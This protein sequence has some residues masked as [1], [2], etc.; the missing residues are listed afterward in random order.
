MGEPLIQTFICTLKA[1]M[2]IAPGDPF[3]VPA[4]NSMFQDYVAFAYS[5]LLSYIRD[6]FSVSSKSPKRCLRHNLD[7]AER[8][9]DFYSNLFAHQQPK[10]L[11]PS[12]GPSS[13][14]C[15]WFR[16]VMEYCYKDKEV[17]I[18]SGIKLMEKLFSH[19]GDREHF[20]ASFVLTSVNKRFFTTT[21]IH[22]GLG[23]QS[24]R[25]GDTICAML[26]GSTLYALHP[27]GLGSFPFLVECSC[28]VSCM[29]R[30]L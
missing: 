12:K 14:P 19:G 2:M 7:S 22:M 6:N 1:G 16:Q 15:R 8:A 11:L 26:G 23:S 25:A 28:M 29:A 24:L 17:A 10:S 13:E 3:L 9:L 30:L 5:Q 20:W 4:N 27:V 21:Q 18:E